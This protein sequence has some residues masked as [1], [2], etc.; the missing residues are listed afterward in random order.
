MTV[1]QLIY[2]KNLF[3]EGSF[4]SVVLGMNS[5]RVRILLGVPEIEYNN[6][7]YN[8]DKLV[9]IYG[10]IVFSFKNYV[11]DGISW[12]SNLLTFEP[13]L[14]NAGLIPLDPW[15]IWNGL[16]L[17]EAECELRDHLIDFRRGKCPF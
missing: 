3:T 7:P 6:N 4:D 15:I 17:M 8:P 13:C 11:L 9:W 2:L 14:P 5:E 12:E 1:P 10:N 16:T